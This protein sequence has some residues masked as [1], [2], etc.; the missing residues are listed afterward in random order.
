M[1]INIIYTMIHIVY[2]GY[3]VDDDYIG[4]GYNIGHFSYKELYFIETGVDEYMLQI[5]GHNWDEWDHSEFYIIVH[6][7]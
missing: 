2:K 5:L 4:G 1:G 6:R 3:Q 7:Y